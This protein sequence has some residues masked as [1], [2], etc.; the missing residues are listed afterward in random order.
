MKLNHPSQAY[1][2]CVLAC[3][4]TC[5]AFLIH[6]VTWIIEYEKMEHTRNQNCCHLALCNAWGALWSFAAEP[7]NFKGDFYFLTAWVWRDI[8]G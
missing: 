8:L 6:V 7:T 4:L 5:T 1:R 2:D 3:V